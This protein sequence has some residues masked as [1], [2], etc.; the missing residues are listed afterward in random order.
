ML[1]RQVSSIAVELQRRASYQTRK[2][3]FSTFRRQG[4]QR[5]DNAP[6]ASKLR[7]RSRRTVYLQDASPSGLSEG[8]AQELHACRVAHHCGTSILS[9]GRKRRS[10][11]ID[12]GVC[13]NNPIMNALVDVCRRHRISCLDRRREAQTSLIQGD[14]G[15][16]G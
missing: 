3:R 5:R 12:G 11:M 14:Q 13:A 16:S 7:G 9:C 2:G 1:R 6:C 15:E 4:H 10:P 8:S